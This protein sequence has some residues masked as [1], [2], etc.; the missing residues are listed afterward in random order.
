[1]SILLNKEMKNTLA[2]VK[3]VDDK[4]Y[5]Y[6]MTCTEKYDRPA[7]RNLFKLMGNIKYTG[8]SAFIA[9]NEQGEYSVARNY[10]L[11]HKDKSG[12]INGLNVI[13]DIPAKEGKYAS[14]GLADACWF[15]SLGFNYFSGA[16]DDGSTPR[17]PMLLLPYFTMD[18]VNEKGLTATVLALHTKEGETP[19]NQTEK[20]K[21]TLVITVLLRELL[22]N[23]ASVDDAV[24]LCKSINLKALLGLD[25]HLFV[26]DASGAAAV[27]DW[28]FNELHV[29]YTDACT[30][31]YVGF[32]DSADIY[33]HGILKEVYPGPANTKKPYCYGFGHGYDRFNAIVT[34]IDN[35]K[36]TGDDMA[37]MTESDM[38]KVI[39]SVR[40]SYTNEVSS[41][42]QYSVIY[43]SQKCSLSVRVLPDYD[44]AF[45]F[46]LGEK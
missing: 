6:Y 33:V 38:D 18:G 3:R 20:G 2:T 17:W 10:D 46:S 27:F 21:K 5:L 37:L 36:E 35:Y 43:N 40:Q 24:K 11:P 34:A 14:I 44:K 28:R 4:G 39:G 22:D 30:N 15:S 31:F 1:M 8:C 7:F 42:T 13:V 45:E 29:N 23:C 19:T 25:Y 26:T 32:T 12:K 9:R 41:H 16:L